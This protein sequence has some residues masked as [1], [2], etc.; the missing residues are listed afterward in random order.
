MTQK[1]TQEV[2]TSH[3]FFFDPW[4]KQ[5]FQNKSMV[6]D[7]LSG[8]FLELQWFDALDAKLLRSRPTNVGKRTLEQRHLDL[9]WE[10][11]LRCHNIQSFTFRCSCCPFRMWLSRV[12]MKRAACVR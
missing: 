10:V 1:E 8:D 12:Q 2:S 4:M 7:L 6:L 11:Q 3:R 5:L 9:V